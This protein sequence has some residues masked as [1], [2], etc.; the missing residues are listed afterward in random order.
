MVLNL[1]SV[2]FKR[3]TPVNRSQEN[4]ELAK[5]EVQR[6]TQAEYSA[7]DRHSHDDD[8]HP[9]VGSTSCKFLKV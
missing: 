6:T 7:F 4:Q 5:M 1:V 8:D 2:I 9:C 3:R